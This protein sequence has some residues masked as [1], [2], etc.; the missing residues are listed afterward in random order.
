MSEKHVGLIAC[1]LI[2]TATMVTGQTSCV[3]WAL[4]IAYAMVEPETG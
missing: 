2:T 3:L 4:I 1:P